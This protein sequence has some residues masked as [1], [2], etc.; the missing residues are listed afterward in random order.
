VLTKTF[1]RL[2]LSA[3]SVEQDW[4]HRIPAGPN[5]GR[6][7]DAV[8]GAKEWMAGKL[9]KGQDGQIHVNWSVV[10]DDEAHRSY[11]S[12]ESHEIRLDRSKGRNVA[13]HEWGHQIEYHVPGVESVSNEFLRHRVGNETLVR[14]RDMF[15]DAGYRDDEFGRGDEFGKAFGERSKWYVGKDYGGNGTTEIVAMGLEQLCLDPI[16]FAIND[17]EFFK[18]ILGILDGSLRLP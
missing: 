17:P 12:R 1:K 14:L 7:D 5:P 3:G 16:E 18:F 13:I 15:P 6:F 4:D 8:Q 10:P 2:N 11:A 9:A